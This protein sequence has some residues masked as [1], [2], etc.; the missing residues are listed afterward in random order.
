M[1]VGARHVAWAMILAGGVLYGSSRVFAPGAHLRSSVWETGPS[2]LILQTILAGPDRGLMADMD[3]LSVFSL[4]DDLRMHR[5]AGGQAHKAWGYLAAYLERAQA[6]DPRFQDTYRL[7]LGLLGYTEGFQS[8]AVGILELGAEAN[9]QNWQYPFF[10]G[11]IAHDQLHDDDRA[12]RLMSMAVRRPG[13]P[14]LALGLAARFLAKDRSPEAS[15]RFLELMRQMMPP[16]Y[17]A[18]LQARIQR[19]KQQYHLD[20]DSQTPGREQP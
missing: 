3:V 11:F 1:R 20:G 16:A 18:P 2:P 4:N 6:L 17:K 14:P 15:L 10:G 19:L 9:P 8:K 7:A 12:Y 13:V 5:F